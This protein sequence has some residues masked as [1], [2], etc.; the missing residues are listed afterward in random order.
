M[1]ADHPAS[2]LSA[3]LRRRGIAS[4]AFAGRAAVAELARRSDPAAARDWNLAGAAGAI[5]AALPY[6]PRHADPPDDPPNGGGPWLRIAPFAAMHRY[7]TLARLLRSAGRA[8]AATLD[9]PARAFRVAVNSRLPEKSLAVAAGLG[10]IGRSSLL[11][12][13]DYG[14][15]CVLGALFLPFEPVDGGS[16]VPP[17]AAEPGALCGD[18]R[19]C[20]DACPTGAIAAPESEPA[21]VD[22]LRC[23]QH[24]TTAEEPGPNLVESSRGDRLY[25]CGDCTAA[26]PRSAGA[27]TPTGGLSPAGDP[28]PT[29]GL[30]PAA[31]A[32]G[33]ALPSERGPGSFV[34]AAALAGADDAS[35]RAL[36]RGTAL[37]L[38]WIPPAALRRFAAGAME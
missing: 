9:L 38:S 37:G 27:F 1:A 14:P 17:E 8:A 31:L 12:S 23:I 4:F 21:G 6:D 11:V 3:E 25:G 28:S 20:V 24:W 13:R 22:R 16:A 2:V 10:F 18:C 26:C 33:L 36:F 7:A 29:G 32:E 15:A 34:A 19:A 5:V 35:I 30:S